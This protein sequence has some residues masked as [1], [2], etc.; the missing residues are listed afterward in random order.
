MKNNFGLLQ[1]S[2]FDENCCQNTKLAD[3]TIKIVFQKINDD[4][5]VYFKITVYLIKRWR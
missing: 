5:I 1:V 3:L 4:V 2:K